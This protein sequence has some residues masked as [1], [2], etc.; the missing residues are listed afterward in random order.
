M[1]NYQ[2]CHSLFTE[3]ETI[4]SFKQ[5]DWSGVTEIINDGY[6]MGV[7]GD[8]NQLQSAHNQDIRLFTK[9]LAEN[10]PNVCNLHLHTIDQVGLVSAMSSQLAALY[11]HNLKLLKS[12]TPLLLIE[13]VRFDIVEILDINL[14][15]DSTQSIP[16][17][18]CQNIQSLT[19]INLTKSFAWRKLVNTKQTNNITFHSLRSLK[20]KAAPESEIEE[21][22]GPTKLHFPVLEYLDI[23]VPT[24]NFVEHVM[25]FENYTRPSVTRLHINVSNSDNETHWGDNM[26]IQYSNGLANRIKTCMP[27][28]TRMRLGEKVTNDRIIFYDKLVNLF[29]NQLVHIDFAHPVLFTATQFSCELTHLSLNVDSIDFRSIPAIFAESLKHLELNSVD[30]S[31][32]W[33]MLQVK[34]AGQTINFK[35]LEK[36][37]LEY[38]GNSENYNLDCRQFI[39]SQQEHYNGP[40]LS[41][42][43]LKKLKL[44]NTTINSLQRIICPG[45]NQLSCVKDLVIQFNGH[46]IELDGSI[47]KN[48]YMQSTSNFAKYLAGKMPHVQ[49]LTMTSSNESSKYMKIFCS[50]VSDYYARQLEAYICYIPVALSVDGFLPGLRHLEIA[51]DRLPLPKVNAENIEFIHIQGNLGNFSWNNFTESNNHENI[52]FDNL[53]SLSLMQFNSKYVKKT[54]TKGVNDGTA[55][56]DHKVTLHMPKL[57]NITL[58]NIVDCS[59]FLNASIRFKH[60]HNAWIRGSYKTLAMFTDSNSGVIESSYVTLEPNSNGDKN[61]DMDRFYK[62][63]NGFF[64]KAT[65]INQ[66]DLVLNINMDSWNAEQIMWTNLYS[67]EINQ[68]TWYGTIIDTLA[69]APSLAELMCD[70]II[71]ND[72]ELKLDQVN[73]ISTS[74]NKLHLRGNVDTEFIDME[75][76]FIKYLL[77]T[78]PTLNGVYWADVEFDYKVFVEEYSELYPHLVNISFWLVY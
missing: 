64:G 67:L 30:Y 41:F 21:L 25:N 11:S 44:Y 39:Q 7:G 51:I 34:S 71:Y 61:M 5:C 60:I 12:Y 1:A 9:L 77:L 52:V 23:K 40:M 16:E 20:L 13:P 36:L 31:F 68:P 78:L 73:P 47:D 69:K 57:S 59:R 33:N 65:R 49:Q 15:E 18:C 42:P 63:T 50:I 19:L 2:Y 45:S 62:I 3:A 6:I 75:N 54:P 46:I 66:A 28:V 70:D 58:E 55:M 53:K 74:L 10:M 29:V 56:C 76:V 37:S 22:V 4:F 32:A 14:D 26:L 48:K 43:R 35:H 72:F 8:E 17:I 24:L 38:S 27:K